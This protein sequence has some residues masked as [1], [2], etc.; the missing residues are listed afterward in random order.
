MR[1]LFLGPIIQQYWTHIAAVEWSASFPSEVARQSF[2]LFNFDL[3]L[4]WLLAFH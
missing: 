2:E 3:N 1:M 4:F